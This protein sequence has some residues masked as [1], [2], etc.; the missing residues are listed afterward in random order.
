[1][2]ANALLAARGVKVTLGGRIV[3]NDIS[4]S[5]PAGHLVALFCPELRPSVETIS[6]PR[7]RN[8]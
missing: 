1:M 6:W 5:L 8:F 4:L 3:L 2:N 7:G